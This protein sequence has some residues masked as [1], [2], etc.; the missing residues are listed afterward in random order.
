MHV[1]GSL[2]PNTLNLK[3]KEQILEEPHNIFKKSVKMCINTEG[4][5]D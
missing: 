5:T 1:V 2:L 4:I 3:S